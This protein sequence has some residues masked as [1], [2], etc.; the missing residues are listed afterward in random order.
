MKKNRVRALSAFA[1]VM[2]GAGW[3]CDGFSVTF[4]FVVPSESASIETQT[5]A[6]PAGTGLAVSNVT[7]DTR[8]EVDAAAT[9]ASI[10]I[11]KVAFADS[12]AA[13]DQLLAQIVVTV[14]PPDGTNN[15]LRVSAAPPASATSDISQFQFN[16]DDD[17]FH[18]TGVAAARRVAIVRLV[19]KIPPGHGVD[20]EQGQGPVRGIRL[21]T[22]CSLR[23]QNGSVRLSQATAAAMLSTGR[24]DVKAED[25]SGSLTM[26]TPKGD[27]VIDLD[28][29]A[30]GQSVNASTNDGDILMGMPHNINAELT[31]RT[32]RGK[33]KFDTFGFDD[34]SANFSV[35]TLTA[36][37][38]NGGPGITLETNEGDVSV[39]G[40]T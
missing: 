16:F 20:V 29:L 33:I 2:I 39:D 3:A 10:Q 11:T 32:N 26:A 28:A 22:A 4:T 30:A 13:A 37:I 6:M 21:D 8:V 34:V 24:G 38:N 17:E 23:T 5:A 12:Q 7:G 31:A 15:N 35:K 27:I 25:H 36:T 40:Q 1:L 19:I 9:Q 14:T 18:V